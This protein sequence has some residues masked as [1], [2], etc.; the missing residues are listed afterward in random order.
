METFV[1]SATNWSTSFA[2]V[3]IIAATSATAQIE[4]ADGKL[5][6]SGQERLRVEYRAENVTFNNA[7]DQDTDPFLLQRARV[8]LGAKPVPWFRAFGEF[9][10]AREIGSTR[11]P[12]DANAE[13][14]AFDWRQGWL[15]VVNYKEFPIGFKIG[16]QELSY[17]DE[18]LIGAFDWN[19]AG[20]VFDAAKL[21]WQTEKAWVELFG[22]DVVL[23]NVTSGRDNHLDD[24][25]YWQD[26]FFGLYAQCSAL[27]F[28][29]TET[30]LLYRDKDNATYD[31]PAR[32]IWTLGARVK[33]TPKFA[34][35]D[36]H[37]EIA[38]QWGE[39]DAPGAGTR[40]FGDNSV[41]PGVDHQALAAVIGGGFTLANCPAKPR[42]GLEY[43]YASGDDNPT[44]GENETFDNLYPTN[45][46]FY[47]Y[48]DVFAWKNV[49][50]PRVTLSATPHKKVVVQLDYHAFWLA[51]STDFW[52]RANQSPV[53]VPAR[54]D[55][56]G[57]AGSYVGSELDL[58]VTWTAHKQL[59]VQ[60]GYSHFFSGD[61]V[62]D[63]ASGNNG[64]DDA[65]FLYAQATYNF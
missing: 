25:T 37:G 63:T 33:S 24:S 65:D 26:D 56:T 19:T 4:F 17:G 8:G 9:Q 29:V 23:N 49:H 14:D 32:E 45:H 36:Y 5:W 27:S 61:Y 35:W 13:E 46:K 42:L 11:F 59:K 54:R 3:S 21:R 22:A 7:I 60:G 53:G 10:D 43:N 2:T 38:G 55:V 18:R 34:P 15:E 62:E 12:T 39:V 51:E 16:R 20:R 58:T 48:M 28:Q 64:N 47:G 44:D 30:Y 50:N 52:Y 6:V 57:V 41:A 1:H 40:R 31:G